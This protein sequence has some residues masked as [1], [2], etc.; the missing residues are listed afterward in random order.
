MT[1]VKW[2][3]VLSTLGIAG[4]MSFMNYAGI[5]NGTNL[6]IGIGVMVVNVL[7]YRHGTR[8]VKAG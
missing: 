1:R 4:A 5:G 8:R 3:L 7:L 2:G 6:A